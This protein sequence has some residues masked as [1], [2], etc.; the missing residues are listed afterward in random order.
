M[1]LFNKH[2]GASTLPIVIVAA[3]ALVIGVLVFFGNKQ[4]ADS[5]IDTSKL[6]KMIMLPKSRALPTIEFTSH[7]GKTITSSELTGKW[8]ILFFGFTRC[9]DICPT[10]LQTLKLVKKKVA[11]AGLWGHYEV[12]MISVDPDR[13]TVERLANYVPFFDSEFIGLRAPLDAVTEYAKQ[14]GIVFF[15]GE[16]S[17]DGN[18]DVDH[19]ASLIVLNPQGEYAAA[20][21]AP[22]Q[23]DDISADLITL[24]NQLGGPKDQET[25]ESIATS[26][27]ADKP[28]VEKTPSDQ[29]LAITNA[30]I[31]SAPPKATALA[32]YM[33]LTNSGQTDIKLT[34]VKSP[35]FRMCMLHETVVKDGIANMNHLES[36]TIGAGQRIEF[37]PMGMHVMLM[38]PDAPIEP[39]LSVPLTLV[40]ESGENINIEFTVRDNTEIG[41]K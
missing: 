7:T 6:K 35:M 36:V 41:E 3:A 33:T 14:A 39:G 29:Q 23:V 15:K 10:T 4:S 17:D 38:H 8:R 19:G 24:A 28:A 11:D 20:I 18:Y 27:I 1:N 21:T 22:H 31:R 2:R 9:P 13:D 40:T 37:K 34:G 25:A 5:V 12:V 32:G 26:T 30:W 16:V